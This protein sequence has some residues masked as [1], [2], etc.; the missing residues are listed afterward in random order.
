[1]SL[2]IIFHGSYGHPEENWFPWLKKEL[3]KLGHDV[4]VPKFPTPVNQDFNRWLKI[5]EPYFQKFNQDTILVGHS[6]G[7]TFI[8]NILERTDTKILSAFL[9]SGSI[10]LLGNTV[11]DSI[12]ESFTKDDFNWSKIKSKCKSFHVYHSD[13]DPYVPLEKGIEIARNLSVKLTEISGAG[14]FNKDSGYEQFPRIL[15]DIKYE[16]SKDL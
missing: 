7:A 1:M 14:H 13:N 12:T 2:I 15:E 16:L 5:I 6:I 4:F 9:V 8:L 3:E 10:G 11:F